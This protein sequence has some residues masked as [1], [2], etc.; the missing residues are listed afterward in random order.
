MNDTLFDTLHE[1]LEHGLIV[2]A[3]RK[4]V[5]TAVK[6]V[7]GVLY[8]KVPA[9]NSISVDGVDPDNWLDLTGCLVAT[10]AAVD[11]LS[12]PLEEYSPTQMQYTCSWCGSRISVSSTMEAKRLGWSSIEDPVGNMMDFCPDSDCQEGKLRYEE[13]FK[14]K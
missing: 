13:A 9:V 7:D 10:M 14:K 1:A 4:Y 8:G 6:L 11:N 2:V 12:I 3:S 5:I